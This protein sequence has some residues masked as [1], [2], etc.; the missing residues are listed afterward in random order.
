MFI[1]K[2]LEF[3]KNNASKFIANLKQSNEEMIAA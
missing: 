2:F 1:N 3:E